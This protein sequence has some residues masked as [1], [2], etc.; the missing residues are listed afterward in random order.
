VKDNFLKSVLIVGTGTA[1]AQL[2]KVIASPVLSRLYTPEDF[3][4]M[5]VFGS[6]I[7]LLAMV[8]SLKYEW[9]IPIATEND[10]YDVLT[11][12]YG[13]LIVFCL[14]IT[15]LVMIGG[16]S[17]LGLFQ[18][19]ML[20]NYK[21]LIPLGVLALGL[22]TITIQ[23]AYRGRHFKVIARTRFSQSILAVITQMGLGLGFTG[24]IGLLVGRILGEG[25]GVSVGFRLIIKDRI[26]KGLLPN[27]SSYK[28]LLIRYKDFALFSAPSQ[29]LNYAGLQLPVFFL[30]ALFGAAVT[31]AYGMATA[32]ISLPL[33]IVGNSIGD[34]FFSEASR[35]IKENP[36]EI[37]TLSNRLLKR[38]I[39]I[40]LP[41]I[42]ITILIGPQLFSLILGS[43]WQYAGEI[44]RLLVP[45][46]YSRFIFT[47]ISRVYSII[48]KQKEAFLLN[49][50]RIFLVILVFSVSQSFSLSAK[51]TVF[52]YSSTMSLVYFYTYLLA[53]YLMRQEG[54]KVNKKHKYILEELD[55]NNLNKVE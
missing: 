30:S 17:V 35:S 40:G 29:F 55:V 46:V 31:G 12:S 36:Y 2:L 6:L 22:Y 26:N 39:L 15:G 37:L 27:I 5:A 28:R 52:V 23:W 48:E 38:L 33:N 19:E 9:A 14:L 25:S 44:S 24:P 10:A 43:K 34:V 32:V 21:Y 13:I 50:L 18:S 11:L 8:S 4:A 51:V 20:L 49:L 1:G 41:P 53:Q 47:P 54:I 16:R 42:I 7:G 45:V 3:G